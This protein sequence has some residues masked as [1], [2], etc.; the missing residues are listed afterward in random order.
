MDSDDKEVARPMRTARM[1]R[2]ES[3][4]LFRKLLESWMKL[5]ENRIAP[6]PLP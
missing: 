6:A 3:G 4:V 1:R 5:Y 2:P